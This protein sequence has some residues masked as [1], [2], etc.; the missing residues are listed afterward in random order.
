MTQPVRPY[1]SAE[2]AQYTKDHGVYPPWMGDEWNQQQK[3]W[4]DEKLIFELAPASSSQE[5]WRLSP[6][7]TALRYGE[8]KVFIFPKWLQWLAPFVG[9]VLRLFYTLKH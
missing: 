6:G 7:Q 5:V 3:E 9:Y 4:D 8:R 1:M 2:E